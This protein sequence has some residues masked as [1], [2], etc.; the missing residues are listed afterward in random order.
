MKPQPPAQ[1]QPARLYARLLHRLH[2]LMAEGKGDTA[3]VD[4]LRE[5][6]D[7]PWSALTEQEQNRLDGLSEDLYALAEGNVKPAVRTPVEV[8]PWEDALNQ[9]LETGNWDRALE[10]LRSAPASVSPHTIAL[11]QARCW[12]ALD[13]PEVAQLFRRYAEQWEAPTTGE[14]P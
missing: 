5:V 10:L 7:T 14:L 11:L 9:S 1:D 8:R 4:A 12:E 6:M 2:L 3:E 13:D